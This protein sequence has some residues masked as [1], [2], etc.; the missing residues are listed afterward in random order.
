MPATSKAHLFGMALSY[1]RGKHPNASKRVRDLADSMD[2]ET[3]T[4][5]TT[6]KLDKLPEHVADLQ[7]AAGLKPVEDT[8][9]SWHGA[10]PEGP[11]KS[12]IQLASGYPEDA[13]K[14]S[15]VD[16]LIEL[17]DGETPE[18]IAKA[19]GISHPGTE[20]YYELGE[21]EGRPVNL[22]MGQG[23]RLTRALKHRANQ[24][25]LAKARPEVLELVRKLKEAGAKTEP[26]WASALGMEGDPYDAMAGDV[27]QHFEKPANGSVLPLLHE[28]K[29]LSDEG[30]YS[31][32]KAII[33]SLMV[34]H[35]E[36]WVVDDAAGNYVSG[37]THKP[38][39]YQFHL[40]KTAITPGVGTA[41]PTTKEER[42]AALYAHV[43]QDPA[44]RHD[45]L[46]GKLA[47]LEN[48][49]GDKELADAWLS[50]QWLR[51]AAP[52]APTHI[53]HVKGHPDLER[54]V[55]ARLDTLEKRLADTGSLW[56]Q[57][58]AK[59]AAAIPTTGP[60][61][62][63]HALSKLDLAEVEEGARKVID[64]KQISKRPKAVQILN[65]LEGFKRNN[66]T[67]NDLMIH[68][69]PVIP[70]V[71]RPFAVA[72]NTFIAGDANEMY[73]DLFKHRDVYKRIR[74]SLGDA[75][76]GDARL[77]MYD[78]VKGLY[79]FGE[80]V[81]P[82][83]KS[84]G[85]KGFLQTVAGTSPKYGVVQRRLLSKTQ[86]SVGR[87]TVIVDPELSLDQVGI[88]R[89]MARR[90]YS[91]WVQRRLVR[92]GM[93]PADALQHL[94]DKTPHAERALEKEVE[95]RPVLYSRPPS[96]HKF[97][98]LAGKPKLIDGD[99]IA[100]NPLVTTGM[101]MDF[102]GDTV[103][104]HVPASDEAV[105]EAHER[106]MPSKQLFTPRDADK[107]M[108]LPKQEHILG[109]HNAKLRP[110]RQ[111]HF[112][113]TEDEAVAAIERGDVPLRD[114][115]QIRGQVPDATLALHA[116]NR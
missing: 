77:T 86:D 33:H 3:L 110:S 22:K 109:M 78:A 81:S 107:V 70:P 31:Q 28:A 59:A 106:L 93:S 83:P 39:G 47:D 75:A 115:V 49:G 42:A 35:P 108:P 74:Q 91:N 21:H 55:A 9:K 116:P 51:K 38:T 10:L 4:H 80:P 105:R 32:K 7:K 102:D 67:P 18:Q 41:T 50:H 64:R 82:K 5:Y 12:R 76:A 45:D 92:L 113:N 98:F 29:R 8:F 20:G 68:A 99:A 69:V 90:M 6:G 103:N 104:M 36:D 57:S 111:T 14:V 97:S 96:W 53:D 112:F 87:S 94:K 85:V 46:R 63:A 34:M 71:F 95:V 19:L 84:R 60:E 101:N 62:I 40:P 48:G 56:G 73:Q 30:K 114:E 17:Q 79:G 43:T 44:M 58:H 66:I 15:D 61:A 88:P 23:E 72:G 37:V 26:A 2:E 65:I 1:K 24:L 25:A 100:V 11:H 13:G 89:D 52:D 16:A 54:A 27:S